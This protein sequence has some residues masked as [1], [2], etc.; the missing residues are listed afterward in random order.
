MSN[1]ILN[2]F[3]THVSPLDRRYFNSLH[4]SGC[5]CHGCSDTM[6]FE[7]INCINC[8]EWDCICFGDMPD[9]L[10]DSYEEEQR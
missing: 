2:L 1:E 6:R 10:L 9:I 5:Q 4:V 3:S 8:G 7:R